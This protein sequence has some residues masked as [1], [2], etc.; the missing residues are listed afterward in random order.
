M[1]TAPD[2]EF[3]LEKLFLPAWAQETP[4]AT[5]YAK[6]EGLSESSD[7]RGDRR[8]GRRERHDGARPGAQRRGPGPGRGP[9]DRSAGGPRSQRPRGDR[10][11]PR[12]EPREQRE[13]L[14]LPDLSLSFVP[15]D[16]G[17]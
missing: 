1:S 13:P 3:D 17:V 14:P 5:K 10:R 4:S 15:E 16:S 6:Y 7:A 9:Q 8:G 12:P 2:N 11:G